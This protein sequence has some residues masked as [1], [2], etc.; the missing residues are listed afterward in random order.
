MTASYVLL[1]SFTGLDS[2]IGLHSGMVLSIEHRN[3]VPHKRQE[4]GMVIHPGSMTVNSIGKNVPRPWTPD[5]LAE[6]AVCASEH[7]APVAVL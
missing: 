3:V 4:V 5:V 1:S 7:G 2:L 6:L